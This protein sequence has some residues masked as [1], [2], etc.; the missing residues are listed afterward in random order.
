MGG[1]VDEV[2]LHFVSISTAQRGVKLCEQT[3]GWVGGWVGSCCVLHVSQEFT[4]LHLLA[5]KGAG[6]S[7][8]HL[9]AGFPPELLLCDPE[10]A[11]YS[12]LDFKKGVKETFF[13]YEA[14]LGRLLGG[15]WLGGEHSSVRKLA[16]ARGTEAVACISTA[17][18][19]ARH[20]SD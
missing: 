16:E 5:S 18:E 20:A 11:T 12:A 10:N 7:L 19:Q 1:W 6:S 3:R 15:A 14:S 8:A 17:S 9:L 4:D 2:K 13:S